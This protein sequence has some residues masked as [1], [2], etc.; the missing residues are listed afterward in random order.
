MVDSDCGRKRQSLAHFQDDA[1][2]HRGTGSEPVVL[3]FVLT[4]FLPQISLRN[5]RKLDCY[6]N[7]FPLRSKTLW[8][9]P[10]GDAGPAGA[11]SKLGDKAFAA[12]RLGHHKPETTEHYDQREAKPQPLLHVRPL[13]FATPHASRDERG[14]NKGQHCDELD[15]DEQGSDEASVRQRTQLIPSSRDEAEQ[16]R[17]EAVLVGQKQTMRRALIHFQLRMRD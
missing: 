13:P 3:R 6:A 4:R 9:V 5:L 2:K 7:R 11:G 1:G 10:V 16:I 14:I 17:I 8:L 15:R 12:H